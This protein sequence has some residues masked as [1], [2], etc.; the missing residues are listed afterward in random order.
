MHDGSVVR[1]RRVAPDYNPTN[2]DAAYAYVRAAQ[3]RG[4]VVTG[5]LHLDQSA[6]DMHAVAETSATPL[7]DLPYE[8]LCPGRDALAQLMEE[9]R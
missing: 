7:V 2:R 5:L 4:E 3:A 1:F 9:Y 8:E 6:S